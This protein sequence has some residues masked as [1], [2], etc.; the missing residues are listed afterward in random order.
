M[1]SGAGYPTASHSLPTC[2]KAALVLAENSA[3]LTGGVLLRARLLHQQGTIT[4][5]S[6]VNG[7]SK[8]LQTTFFHF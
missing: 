8:V 2:G 3:F 7:H 4:W 1:D 6:S 5:G